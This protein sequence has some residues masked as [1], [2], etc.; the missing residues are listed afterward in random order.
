MADAEIVQLTVREAFSG[1]LGSVSL[2]C[3]IFL[4]VRIASSPQAP[5][6]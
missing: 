2:A 1:V 3:W 4:L 5:E 6:W